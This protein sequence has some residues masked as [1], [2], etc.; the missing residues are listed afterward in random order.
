MSANFK[1]MGYQLEIGT[2]SNQ[3]FVIF[4][5]ALVEELAMNFVFYVWKDLDDEFKVV[6]LVTSWRTTPPDVERLCI[7]VVEWGKRQT[8]LIFDKTLATHFKL[9]P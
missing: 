5:R 8:Q 2:V 1:K 3:V 7:F 6:R 9:L 4:P